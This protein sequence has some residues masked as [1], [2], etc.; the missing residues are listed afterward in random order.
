[1][2]RN[3]SPLTSP[4]A[5]D[6]AASATAQLVLRTGAWYGDRHIH[7]R[8]P[9]TWNV[10]QLEPCL[11]APLTDDQIA[12]QLESP[13]GQPPIR[14]LCRGKRSPVVLVDDLNRPTPVSR[15]LPHVLRH[16]RDGG[17]DVANVVI[18]IAT[19]T[20]GPS[21]E[22]A[23]IRKVGASVASS[24]R[25]HVHDCERNVVR[26]GRTSFG[27]PVLVDQYVARGDL[28]IGIGGLYPN[29]TAGFGGGSKLALG[30]LG[31]AS[32][33]GL[34]YGHEP[35]GWGTLD[36]HSTFRADLDEV[37]EMIGLRTSITAVVNGDR[38]IVGMRCG[39][40]SA[41]YAEL[42]QATAE[43]FRAPA[44]AADTDLVISNAYPSD[45]SLTF[46][47][48]KGIVPLT[49][50]P[51]NASRVV[52]AACSEGLGFHGLTPFLN[53]PPLHRWRKAF[54]RG[55]AL[56][57]RPRV[58]QRKVRA[59]VEGAVRAK[60][61]GAAPVVRKP[62]WMFRPSERDAL[63]LPDLD[64]GMRVSQEWE[65]VLAAV[66]TEQGGRDALNVMVY[67]C[68]PLQWVQ[69]D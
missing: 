52:I 6:S 45:T 28:I 2:S 37:A 48:M 1:M 68:A 25:V 50:A 49:L 13:V 38:E 63:P 16:F 67:R 62:I 9:S 21:P 19:G 30:V 17:I 60:R 27:T 69:R 47:R 12:A 14:E 15:V 23:L 58:L 46:V 26:M 57:R 24:C 56:L 5:P 20:H 3:V 64:G 36:P 4:S 29:H 44:P 55:S 65:E 59:R 10:E 22:H 41:Y 11:G 8:L 39:D 42:A 7:L 61:H 51:P 32:I 53:A 35:V 33:A 66:T 34:H 18:V 43:Q 54:L 31:H 40:P